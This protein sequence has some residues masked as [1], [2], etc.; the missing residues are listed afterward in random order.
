MTIDISRRD[1]IK[2]TL[3]GLIAACFATPLDALAGNAIVCDLNISKRLDFPDEPYQFF[4]STMI[5][6]R[7]YSF[8]VLSNSHSEYDA[9]LISE[10]ARDRI[11]SKHKELHGIEPDGFRLEINDKT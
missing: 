4:L 6:G 9:K 2:S 7:L 3:I 8:S 5:G 10:S 11:F 1:A